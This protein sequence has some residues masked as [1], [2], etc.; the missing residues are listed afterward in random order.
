M[1]H[2]SALENMPATTSQQHGAWLRCGLRL[3]LGGK[4]MSYLD[5]ISSLP[6]VGL[7]R[8]A[9]MVDRDEAKAIAA[10]ADARISELVEALKTM[11]EPFESEDEYADALKAAHAALAKAGADD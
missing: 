10:R 1:A 8:I 2:C 6:N 4:E 11:L 7:K 9:W 3:R 5:Q